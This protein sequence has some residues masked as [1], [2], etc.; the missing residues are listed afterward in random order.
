MFPSPSIICTTGTIK[1]NTKH[2]IS[3]LWALKGLKSEFMEAV[4]SLK[5]KCI[6]SKMVSVWVIKK[7][8]S[9]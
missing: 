1:M 4:I 6:E 3:I 7:N 9:L 2:P 5:L 8:R